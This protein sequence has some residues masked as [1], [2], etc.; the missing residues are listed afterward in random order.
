MTRLTDRERQVLGLIAEGMGVREIA[1]RLNISPDT[2][3]KHRDNA[4]RRVGKGSQV[5]AVR[6]LDRDGTTASA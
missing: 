3:R 5:A 2:V 6:E 1:P 4:V